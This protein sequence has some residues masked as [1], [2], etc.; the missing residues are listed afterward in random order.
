MYKAVKY[1][2]KHNAKVYPN[3]RT[4]GNTYTILLYPRQAPSHKH[5]HN[6]PNKK[7][8]RKGVATSLQRVDP[9]LDCL[10]PLVPLVPL[11]P[12]KTVPLVQRA[13]LEPRAFL[14]HT[15]FHVRFAGTSPPAHTQTP[16]SLLRA[17]F[18]DT[19]ALSTLSLTLSP[20][21]PQTLSERSQDSH[22]LLALFDRS[23]FPTRPLRVLLALF[24]ARWI[25]V[26]QSGED[27]L[28][29]P[30]PF[31]ASESGR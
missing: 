2:N 14:T 9:Q 30:R 11:V 15:L 7:K 6:N 8:H 10:A 29:L 21:S 18:H 4:H 13:L 26:R 5:L 27:T 3:T 19:S 31:L 20:T 12:R 17:L 28:P 1:S 16:H 24:W 22:S 23:A 25:R